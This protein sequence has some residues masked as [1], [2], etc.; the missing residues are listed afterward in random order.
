[1]LLLQLL[2]PP[3]N[4]MCNSMHF[5]WV[6]PLLSYLSSLALSPLSLLH[7]LE[8]ILKFPKMKLNF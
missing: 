8:G 7:R 1:M 3:N 2:L 6:T 4:K 5:L